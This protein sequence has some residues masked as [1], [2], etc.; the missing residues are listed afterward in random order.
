MPIPVSDGVVGWWPWEEAEKLFDEG[1]HTGFDHFIASSAMNVKDVV[2]GHDGFIDGGTKIYLPYTGVDPGTGAEID[3]YSGICGNLDGGVP[4]RCAKDSVSMGINYNIF[5]GINDPQTGGNAERGCTIPKTLFDPTS[6][7]LV[8]WFKMRGP[9]DYLRQDVDAFHAGPARLQTLFGD[10]AVTSGSTHGFEVRAKYDINIVETAPGVFHN[11]APGT[12]TLFLNQV[13][14]VDDLKLGDLGF[15][16]WFVIAITCD[17]TTLKVYRGTDFSTIA[18]T[19][20]R[21]QSQL[22][23][24]ST[25][26]ITFGKH[27]NSGSGDDGFP[28]PYNGSW[29]ETLLWNRALSGEDIKKIPTACDLIARIHRKIPVKAQRVAA[30]NIVS[31]RGEARTKKRENTAEDLNNIVQIGGGAGAPVW[32]PP[33]FRLPQYPYPAHGCYV[34]NFSENATFKV[35]QNFTTTLIPNMAEWVELPSH[36]WTQLKF[37]HT[38]AKTLLPDLFSYTSKGW[39]LPDEED[40]LKFEFPAWLDGATDASGTGGIHDIDGTPL[41][42]ATFPHWVIPSTDWIPNPGFSPVLWTDT[43]S[44]DPTYWATNPSIFPHVYQDG[45]FV[46]THGKLPI[47]FSSDPDNFYFSDVWDVYASII[48]PNKKYWGFGWDFGKQDLHTAFKFRVRETVTNTVVGLWADK[49]SWMD[50]FTTYGADPWGRSSSLTTPGFVDPVTGEFQWAAYS[51]QAHIAGGRRFVIEMYHNA[52]RTITKPVW[53]S[54]SMM[55]TTHFPGARD[56]LLPTVP[57]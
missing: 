21:A 42:P 33:G 34:F 4:W 8:S 57:V 1:A 18:L 24:G 51:R 35:N 27:D 39:E 29:D 43:G 17:G 47:P 3:I 46:T 28:F 52:G 2:S 14:F 20:Q 15:G 36:T 32:P 44:I 38:E 31:S 9:Y 12:G 19:D 7:T 11:V 37:P 16:G 23:V 49:G 53:A 10:Q 6:F 22:T 48:L 55:G 45:E 25:G 5:T 13:G 40:Y 41:A 54:A 26:S 30:P 56:D 50:L